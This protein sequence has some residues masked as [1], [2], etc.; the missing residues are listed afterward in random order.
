MK[1][2]ALM[3]LY[4]YRLSSDGN[5]LISFDDTLEGISECANYLRREIPELKISHIFKHLNAIVVSA[6]SMNDIHFIQSA[7]CVV[8]VEPDYLVK[9]M[10]V[11]K[12]QNVSTSWGIDRIDG[13]LDNKYHYTYT[14]KGVRVY[15][16]DSGIQVNHDEFNSLSDNNTTKRRAK[17]GKNLRIDLGEIV[18]INGDTELM[19]L[20]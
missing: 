15:I 17:C 8:Y 6:V 3:S 19:W 7:S 4:N 16:V 11:Q 2:N 18:T 13:K 14:G 20:V 9:A 1:S 12:L 10:R 5:Y